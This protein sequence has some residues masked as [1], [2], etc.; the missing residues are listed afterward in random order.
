MDM[1]L[2][3]ED[4][5]KM[6]MDMEETGRLFYEALADGTD[7]PRAVDL[8]RMLATA[9]VSHHATF[10]KMYESL[11][12]GRSSVRWSDTRANE[13]HRLVKENIQPTPADVRKVAMGGDL[14]AAIALARKMEQDAIRFYTQMIDAVDAE[15]V[16]T[17]KAI[18]KSEE[19]HLRDLVAFAW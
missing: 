17:V 19:S 12:A 5:L 16:D 14:T 2:T 15:S 3:G 8:F 1:T 18:V 13:F 4:V 6:A 10:K 7:D 9:E 11:L